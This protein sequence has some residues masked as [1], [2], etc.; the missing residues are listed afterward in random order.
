MLSLAGKLPPWFVL[1]SFAVIGIV[2]LICLSVPTLLGLVP[3]QTIPSEIGTALLT[4]LFIAAILGFTIDRWM[5]DE[6]REEAIKAT[7]NAIVLPE[8]QSELQRIFRYEFLCEYHFMRISIQCIASDQVRV[9]TSTER[10]LRNISGGFR[11]IPGSIHIDEWGFEDTKSS[12]ERCSIEDDDGKKDEAFVTTFPNAYSMRAETAKISVPHD[13]CV[14]VRSV[15]SEIKRMNDHFIGTFSNPTKDPIVQV[16]ISD[17]L[18][19]DFDFGRS[20]SPGEK[21]EHSEHM[22]IHRLM[23]MYF[24]GFY[25]KARWWPKGWSIMT[26]H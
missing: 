24:P 14:T 3:W 10:R 18:T 21:V 25:M 8:F 2:G 6:L 22:R 26:N 17:D 5:K 20:L 7:L 9:T 12:I 16:E 1:V 23:G 4:A 11:E 13:K 19:Y 15:F